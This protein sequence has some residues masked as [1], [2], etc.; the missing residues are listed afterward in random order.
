MPA[1][2]L[3]EK[4][5]ELLEAPSPGAAVEVLR[6]ADTAGE[7]ERRLAIEAIERHL[8]SRPETRARD[9]ASTLISLRRAGAVS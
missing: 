2:V 4:V 7:A 1:D 9:V 3:L 5:A 8:R 6:A